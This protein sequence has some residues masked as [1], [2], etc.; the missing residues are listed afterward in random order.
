MSADGLWEGKEPDKPHK[1]GR[2]TPD[3]NDRAE[4]PIDVPANYALATR[5]AHFT[6]NWTEPP[7]DVPADYTPP[8]RELARTGEWKEPPTEEPTVAA[9][10]ADDPSS[11]SDNG[12]GHGGR[13]EEFS[14]DRPEPWLERIDG[15]LDQIK[16]E[17][18]DN[19]YVD[20]NGK[21]TPEAW[22]SD[23]A[24]RL[25]QERFDLLDEKI[26]RSDFSVP[27]DKTPIFYTGYSVDGTRNHTL[28]S[29][30]AK[31]NNGTLIDEDT[32]G[33]TW[34]N[35]LN[36]YDKD[37]PIRLLESDGMNDDGRR[38]KAKELWVEASERYANAVAQA[39]RYVVAFVDP[40]NR[41][42]IYYQIERPTLINGGVRLD[43]RTA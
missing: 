13:L 16:A 38:T 26:T 15:R 31:E 40:K 41:D 5:T 25:A 33:G 6:D 10:D 4:P 12:A 3:S 22:D 36:P 39:D 34:L 42:G 37:D 9:G 24:R 18:R 32:Q 21:L 20:A 8:S 17:F 27:E 29:R 7:T 14:S 28:A 11:R 1:P 35:Q 2:Q 19:G 23:D 43:E 30:Y